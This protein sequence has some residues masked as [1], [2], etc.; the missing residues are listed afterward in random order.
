MDCCTARQCQALD[1]LFDT[2]YA[3]DD[4]KRYQKKGPSRSTRLLLNALHQLGPISGQTLLD[5]GGGIGVIPFELFKSGLKHATGVDASRAF[6]QVAQREAERRGLTAQMTFQF[7]NFVEHAAALENADLVT[8][9]RVICC[10][11]DMHALVSVAASRAQRAFAWVSP[12]D[13]AWMRFAARGWN[14]AQRVRRDP[15]RFFVHPDLAIHQLLRERGFAPST[16]Q[17]AGVWQVNVW[18]I[19][20]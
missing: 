4:L 12:V 13:S 9:D 14:F 5:I 19:P 11:P 1:D 6:L 10:Y 2:K 15:F 8:L 3:E 20:A 16:R 17:T 18:S 7:G